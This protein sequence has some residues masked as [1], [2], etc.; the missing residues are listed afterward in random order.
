MIIENLSVDRRRIASIT[1]ASQDN[2]AGSRQE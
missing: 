2:P 1:H